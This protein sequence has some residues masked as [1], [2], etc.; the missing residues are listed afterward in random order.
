MRSG[1]PRTILIV[2]V[3]V[4]AF[5]N[6]YPTLGWMLISEESRQEKLAQWQEED[7]ERA[8]IRQSTWT[9]MYNSVV[10]WSQFDR[11]R[12]INLG[13]DLQGGIHMVLGFDASELPEQRQAEIE[14][15]YG[16]VNTY[17]QEQLVEQVRRRVNE[18]EAREPIIQALG[19]DQV[20]VQLPG[21]KDINRA[22][23]LITRVA[24]L[25][26]HLVAGYEET[27]DVFTEIRDAFPAFTDYIDRPA[28][29]GEP[30]RVPQENFSRVRDIIARA[31][32]QGIVPE[33]KTIAFSP[34]PKPWA[35]EQM[36]YIYLMDR[37]PAKTGE[38]L[39]SANAQ[40]DPQRPGQWLINFEWT[41]QAGAEFGEMTGA[42]VG[43]EMAIVIDNVVISAPTINERIT[44]SGQVTGN[45]GQEEA[46][47]L[48]IALN[49]GSTLVQLREEYT[50]VV[51]P[52]LGAESVRAGVSSALA[53][54]AIVGVFIIVYYLWAGAV[55][56]I[57]LFINA[58]LVIAAMSYFNMTLTLPGI[59]GLILTIGMAVD[60]NVLIFER[61]REELRLG[62]SLAASIESGFAR[63]A[64]TIL[65]ANVTTLIA[66]L[67]LMQF[68]TGPIEGFAIALSI[69]V[70]CSVF[71]AL[72]LV[73]AML[74]LLERLKVVKTLQMLSIFKPNIHIPFLNWRLPAAIASTVLIIGGLV[75]FGYRGADNFGVDFTEG[76]NV[77]VKLLAERTI[78]VDEVRNQLSDAGFGSAVVQ[79]AGT[80]DA[81][82]PNHFIIRVA[83]GPNAPGNQNAAGGA[84]L[85][86]VA[87]AQETPAEQA[88]APAEETVPADEAAAPA[89]EA[90][91]AEETAPAAGAPDDLAPAD[92]PVSVTPIS[93][94]ETAAV[95]ERAE[96]P[97]AP[98]EDRILA[99]LAPL[100]DAGTVEEGI[101]VETITKVG[102]AV[103]EQLRWDALRAITYSLIFIF[104]Y[105]AFRFEA[106]FSLG[107]VA[108]LA[109][110]VLFTVG[111]LAVFGREISMPV[112]AAV[113]T[114]IGYSLNDTIVVFDRIRED[115]KAYRG[116]GYSLLEVMNLS[117]NETLS[118]TIL[119]SL[120]TLFV[121]V[122]L[123]IFGGGEI[124][125]FAFALIIGVLV[126]TYSSIFVASPVV[127]LWQYA[128]GRHLLPT[129]T[130][131]DEQKKSRAGVGKKKKKKSKRAEAGTT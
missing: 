62:H 50:G 47:D 63:A 58:I 86:D 24:K 30:F 72:V 83:A 82:D 130:G 20:Q 119:T 122:V 111:M 14:A 61:I 71:T 16:D 104:L 110:D 96:A 42:N 124:N 18:F 80:G 85:V 126:G 8:L 2:A 28:L 7:S 23:E 39:E 5:I 45:F 131:D 112:V 41:N 92:A 70:V 73:R 68:G 95:P 6:I 57:G 93:E 118:R 31:E 105:I 84:W 88:A 48:A 60:A 106:R 38:G 12:V 94:T 64:I 25:D 9:Q 91:P 98:T 22:R 128:R 90:A 113:L 1:M 21:E 33:D 109:H 97:G 101:E 65:D 76:T 99:A 75:V 10:R 4:L 27:V 79:Q 52:S 69:G 37:E 44:A 103:G 32:A 43:R 120:T 54:L 107:A 81:T 67:V 29:R 117:I 59:A 108:A 17:L 125:D 49:S 129:D 121:V 3:L 78:A 26:F 11:E 100:T 36:Y 127:W 34:K 116:K 89:D 13:L 35:S 115:M 66:A 55:S 87:H 40:P 123:F 53:G 56:V 77:Q 74:E 15:S 46:R 114:I 51:G 102:P 19:T